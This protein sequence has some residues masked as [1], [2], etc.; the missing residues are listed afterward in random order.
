MESWIAD[1]VWAVWLTLAALLVVLEMFSGELVLLMFGIGATVSSG[2]SAFGLDWGWTIAVLAAVSTLLLYFVR[3]PV[4]N[5][6]HAGPTLSMGHQRVIGAS[7]VVTQDVTAFDGRVF[8]DNDDWT[9][10]SGSGETFAIGTPI[11]VIRLDGVTAIVDKE[12]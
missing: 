11:V 9:A 12:S 2:A 7:G 8:V 6:L 4:M 5:R 10:R 1:N 3:P